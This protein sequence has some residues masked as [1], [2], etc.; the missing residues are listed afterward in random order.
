MNSTPP[1]EKQ[2]GKLDYKGRCDNLLFARDLIDRNK[3]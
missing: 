3:Q 1:S 2:F